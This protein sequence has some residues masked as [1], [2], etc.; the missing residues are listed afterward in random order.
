MSSCCCPGNTDEAGAIRCPTSGSAGAAVD[1]L[2]VKALLTEA[3]LRRLSARDYRFCPDA[4]CDVVYFSADGEP[5]TTADV[6]VPVWQKLPFGDRPICY[7]FGESEGSIR[8]E[9]AACGASKAVARIREHIAADR[10]ACDVRNP[11]G[12]C[13]LGDVTAAVKRVEDSVET[14]RISR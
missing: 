12:A 6:R 4:G 11:R 1:R 2:T 7:C 3:A 9:V 8:S 10:C 13:C 14:A 5:F